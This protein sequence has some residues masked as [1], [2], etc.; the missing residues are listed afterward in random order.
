MLFKRS[1]G[2]RYY[3]TLISDTFYSAIKYIG[4]HSAT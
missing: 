3:G 1:I 4:K 2:K